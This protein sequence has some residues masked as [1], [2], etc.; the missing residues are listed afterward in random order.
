MDFNRYAKTRHVMSDSDDETYTLVSAYCR[1][2]DTIDGDG[3]SVIVQDRQ[4][5]EWTEK[6]Q[7]G[8]CD[9]ISTENQRIKSKDVSCLVYARIS[10]I[11]NDS[12][13][14]SMAASLSPQRSNPIDGVN[15]ASPETSIG[16]SPSPQR[17]NPIDGVN[18]APPENSIGASL[19]P[20]SSNP[21]DGV[22]RASP[23]NS[24]GASPSP[25]STETLPQSSADAIKE[26]SHVNRKRKR[27]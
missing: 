22:N 20:R 17:S 15:R 6:T 12:T 21:I 26:A 13:E 18:R 8:S 14:N 27:H 1:H 23:E 3:W 5:N 11:L 16:A 4:R 25:R 2:G 9:K 24:I 7:A 19:S 10:K